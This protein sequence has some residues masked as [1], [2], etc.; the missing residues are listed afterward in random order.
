MGLKKKERCDERIWGIKFLLSVK[1]EV[2][3]GWIRFWVNKK[4]PTYLNITYC[5]ANENQRKNYNWHCRFFVE[6]EKPAL[7]GG[8]QRVANS[9]CLI[10]S[11]FHE[12]TA[13]NFAL[14][15]IISTT[16]LVAAFFITIFFQKVANVLKMLPEQKQN[17]K[18][19]FQADIWNFGS[20]IW[21]AS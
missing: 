18:N 17:R 6:A 5:F 19:H 15:I 13:W 3:S 1:A 8:L 9:Y 21:N 4:L 16:S 2:T 14:I 7:Q 20:S 10:S 11:I 12:T